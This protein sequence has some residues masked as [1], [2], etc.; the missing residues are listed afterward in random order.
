MWKL[1]NFYIMQMCSLLMT[2]F[3]GIKVVPLTILAAMCI[4]F[5]DARQILQPIP[6]LEIAIVFPLFFLDCR[7]FINIYDMQMR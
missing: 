1:C 3:Y 6:N 4:G 5:R 7:H 2:I